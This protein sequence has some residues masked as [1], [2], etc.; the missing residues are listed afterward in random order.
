ML[1]FL[2]Q[3]GSMNDET[4]NT[5]DTKRDNLRLELK[6]LRSKLRRELLLLVQHDTISEEFKN[7]SVV[8][9]WI[10]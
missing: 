6:E 5:E 1:D 3:G 10:K 8:K 7:D 4:T 9:E 2:F